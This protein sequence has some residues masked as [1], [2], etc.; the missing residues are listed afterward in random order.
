MHGGFCIEP[1]IGDFR[2]R[3][4]LMVEVHFLSFYDLCMG[5]SFH[6]EFCL[7][8]SKM[9]VGRFKVSL[10]G[11]LCLVRKRGGEGRPFC[12]NATAA[13]SST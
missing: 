11:E 4:F 10:H 5:V 3:A 6:F 13:R 8:Y 7:G 2:K 12:E 9:E 1:R